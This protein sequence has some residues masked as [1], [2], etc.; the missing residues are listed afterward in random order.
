MIKNLSIVLASFFAMAYFSAC[1]LSGGGTTTAGAA[2]LIAQ[3]SPSYVGMDFYLNG[4]QYITNV[5]YLSNT[6]YTTVASGTYQFGYQDGNYS[7]LNTS[8]VLEPSTYYSF[9][10]YDSIN[11]MKYALIADDV[12]VPTN[13]SARIRFL[14]LSPL[15]SAVDF[16]ISDSALS[17]GT[18]RTFNDQTNLAYTKFVSVPASNYNFTVNLAGTKTRLI[19]IPVA[20]SLVAGKIYTFL[21][22]GLTSQNN[23]G[24]GTGLT[25][26]MIQHN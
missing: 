9:Y 19:T 11:T 5:S 17:F 21:L 16:G 6:N 2:F 25:L 8:V 22:T 7:F 24:T 18:H 14:E 10:T 12:T 1:S 23:T 13:D 4:S 3:E 20:E 26:K 15:D